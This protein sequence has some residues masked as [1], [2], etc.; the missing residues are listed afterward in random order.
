MRPCLVRNTAVNV[1]CFSLDEPCCARASCVLTMVKRNCAVQL[2]FSP[3]FHPQSSRMR[4]TGHTRK[5][6]A[7]MQAAQSLSHPLFT[8]FEGDMVTQLSRK[9]AISFFASEQM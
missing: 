3:R 7:H 6:H 9:C 8:M 1:R 2:A 4:S 5:Q